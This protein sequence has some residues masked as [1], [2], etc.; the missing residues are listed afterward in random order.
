MVAAIVLAAA[1]LCALSVAH[2]TGARRAVAPDEEDSPP[3]EEEEEQ[4]EI[5][6]QSIESEP[7]PGSEPEP[8]SKP[9]HEEY[10]DRLPADRLGK[11]RKYARAR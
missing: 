3:L 9:Q 11:W 6:V 7:G 10:P 1:C 5:E 4:P 2:S 8:A